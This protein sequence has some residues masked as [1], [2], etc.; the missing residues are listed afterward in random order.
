MVVFTVI[1]VVLSGTNTWYFDPPLAYIFS[2]AAAALD[3]SFD[4][5]ISSDDKSTLDKPQDVQ[6]RYSL[7]PPT[8]AVPGISLTTEDN[9]CGT[10]PDYSR[11]P[12]AHSLGTFNLPVSAAFDRLTGGSLYR[13]SSAHSLG[14]L[15]IG[16]S[17]HT[18]WGSNSS[19][20]SSSHSLGM[21]SLS[22]FGEDG[23]SR[24]SSRRTSAHSLGPVIMPEMERRGSRGS[25][26]SGLTAMDFQSQ[27][28]SSFQSIGE[29]VMQLF[30]GK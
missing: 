20:R 19:R 5:L 27:R 18:E 2:A 8:S 6:R 26:L 25:I 16:L 17:G 28:R 13:R 14:V 7:V 3:L 12:S 1:V 21:Y 24:Q 10:S 23:W 29:S 15:P 22:Y 9:S 11:R 30:S 4:V